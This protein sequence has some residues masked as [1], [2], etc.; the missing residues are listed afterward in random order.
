MAA[1]QLEIAMRNNALSPTTMVSADEA[2][3]DPGELRESVNENAAQNSA[4]NFSNGSDASEAE[5]SELV[6]LDPDHPLMRRFQLSL[7]D[8]LNKHL[9]QSEVALREKDEE[10]RREK[11]LH[12]NT[13]CELYNFQQE[14]AKY[15]MQLEKKHAEYADKEEKCKAAQ[16]KLA[17]LRESYQKSLKGLNDDTKTMHNMRDEVD[18]VCLRLFYLNNAKDEM[19]GDIMVL[20]RASEKAT[21]DLS[22]FEE[23]KLRQDMLVDRIQTKVDQLKEDIALYEAQITAQES[24]ML[25]NQQL[26]HEVEAQIVGIA[27]DRKHLAAQWNTSLLGLQRRNEAYAALMKAFNDLKERLLV[28]EN[29]QVAYRRS[30]SKEQETHEQL[31]VL[32]NKNE[33]DINSLKKQIAQVQSKHEADKHSYSTYQRMLQETERHLAQAQSEYSAC[34]SEVES[35]RKQIEKE[36]LKR[37]EL[38]AKISQELRDRLT[39]KK[40]MDYVKKLTVNVKDQS[41]ELVSQIA[42]LENQIAHYELCTASKKAENARLKEVEDEIEHEIEEKNNLISKL[43][44]EIHH[45]SIMVE[46]K[47]GGID[48]LNKKLER[49]LHEQGGQ[50]V[51]PLEALINNLSKAI[52]Q[53]QEEI[54]ELEQQWLKEQNELVQHVNEREGL[55]KTMSRLNK[56]LSIL[57]QKKLRVDNEIAIQERERAELQR[58]LKHLQYDTQRL[59]FLIAKEKTTGHN[60]TR[61]NMLAETDFV[62][63]LREKEVEAVELQAKVDGLNKEREDMLNELVEV[64]RTIMLWEK[65]VQLCDETRRAVDC[66]LGQGEMNVMRHEIHRMEVRK[67]SLIQQQEKLLQ[68]LE[69]S[70]SKR[71]L[72]VMQADTQKN[73]KTKAKMRITAQR[74]V[75]DLKKR[76]KTTKQLTKNCSEELGEMEKQLADIEKLS[77]EKKTQLESE[78]RNVD[79]LAEEL[80]SFA[81]QKQKNL[82]E[83]QMK[84]HETIY[85]EQ[86]REGRYRRLCPSYT[87]AEAEYSRQL[88]KVR[89]L[90]MVV[91]KLETEYPQVKRDMVPV[92][93][94]LERRL[95]AEA[96]KAEAQTTVTPVARPVRL[97]KS[98]EGTRSPPPEGI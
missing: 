7:K 52:A 79:Q 31:T 6:V 22:K 81:D 13:G 5:L 74:Q 32:V 15:Q 73:Q 59:N 9:D 61:E 12:V 1:N 63:A 16:T 26:L 19:A 49:L 98:G 2:V 21:T 90:L 20:K 94:L 51:G 92:R 86:V 27:L 58:E 80:Q 82:F 77:E 71:D 70:V 45:A 18:A 97:V 83:I 23:D 17:Q 96:E 87:S 40:A 44:A 36:A 34:Q 29:E 65:K 10:V 25:N 30:I 91:D 68:A 46:R 64:E 69:R 8:M 85:W 84:Q 66:D 11:E 67:N 39:A 72:I 4:N 3:E 38:E 33:A 50:E 53:K 35:M 89:S 88:G 60:L 78:Q 56:Q 95:Q 57:A 47:Q 37:S 28:L 75:E 24:E 41:R 48:I 43:E 55:V 14:L 93:S 76:V 42:Q 62:R 54:G